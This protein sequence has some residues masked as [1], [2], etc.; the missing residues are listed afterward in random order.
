MRE[1]ISEPIVVA[2][3]SMNIMWKN[4][5]TPKTVISSI[6][7]LSIPNKKTEIFDGGNMTRESIKTL[8]KRLEL[9]MDVAAANLDFWKSS[10]NP[11]STHGSPQE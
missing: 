9:E 1:A 6:K 8:T 10:G 11:G 3:F 7:E 4:N 2:R 5:I